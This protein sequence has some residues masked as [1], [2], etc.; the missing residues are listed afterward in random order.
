MDIL[1]FTG[2][3]WYVWKP[4]PGLDPSF[5][6]DTL[7]VGAMMYAYARQQGKSEKDAHE[8]AERQIYENVYCLTF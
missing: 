8:Y 3:E 1:A 7:R 5:G 6:Q 4:R 2:T